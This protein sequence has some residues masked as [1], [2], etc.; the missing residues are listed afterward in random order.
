MSAPRVYRFSVTVRVDEY[1][2]AF[3]DPEW[4]ADAAAGA[5]RNEYGLACV[6]EGIEEANDW[7]RSEP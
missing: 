4:I 5:L 7:E 1:H 3:Y 2:P 6:Y